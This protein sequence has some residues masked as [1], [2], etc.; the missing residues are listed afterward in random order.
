MNFSIFIDFHIFSIVIYKIAQRKK[1]CG[2][3][4]INLPSNFNDNEKI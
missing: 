1:I 2:H 3:T 4:E